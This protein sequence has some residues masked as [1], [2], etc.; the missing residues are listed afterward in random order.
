MKSRL[1][2][3]AMIFAAVSFTSVSAA[4][5]TT[6]PATASCPAGQAVQGIDFSKR[7][8]TC[9]VLPTSTAES[10]ALRVVDNDGQFVGMLVD[11]NSSSYA[12]Q[13]GNRWYLFLAQLRDEGFQ[14]I[15]VTFFYESADCS[16]PPFI[17][18]VG[19][20]LI[21]PAN[22]VGAGASTT[23]YVGTPGTATTI[24]SL[25]SLRS[26]VCSPTRTGLPEQVQVEVPMQVSVNTTLPWR[27]TD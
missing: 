17:L 9:V 26:G 25:S 23:F 11:A 4:P 27:V 10:D 24:N 13:V 2:F 15:G 8:V 6:P 18:D 21:V 3:T 20:L 7:T 22:N 16:G 1:L 19:R 5:P 12:R 14:E